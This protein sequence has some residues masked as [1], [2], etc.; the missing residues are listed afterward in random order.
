MIKC[1]TFHSGVS[2]TKT[3]LSTGKIHLI[4][5]SLFHFQS[6]LMV[7]WRVVLPFCGMQTLIKEE[8]YFYVLWAGN[9]EEGNGRGRGRKG[10][11]E[12]ISLCLQW[13]WKQNLIW[14]ERNIWGSWE[15]V[16]I[17]LLQWKDIHVQFDLPNPEFHNSENSIIRNSFDLWE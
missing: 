8:K 13:S 15:Y 16:S 9:H 14:K 17:R 2:T 7:Q 10:W 5:Q 11:V 4:S 1:D 12:V 6:P 3:A